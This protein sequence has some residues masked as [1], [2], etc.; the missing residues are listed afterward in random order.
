VKTLCIVIGM[1]GVMGL[2]IGVMEPFNGWLT[3]GAILVG[4]SIIALAVHQKTI[5]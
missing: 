1:V 5:V 2:I 4:A 3:A